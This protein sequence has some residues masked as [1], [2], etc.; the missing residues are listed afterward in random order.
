MFNLNFSVVSA[1]HFSISLCLKADDTML[2]SG[3]V[4]DFH[5]QAVITY[6]T[7]CETSVFGSG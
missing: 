4:E 1:L 2:D 7:Q 5:A 6:Q 3:F